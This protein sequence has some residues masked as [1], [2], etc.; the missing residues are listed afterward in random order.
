MSSGYNIDTATRYF[1]KINIGSK[2]IFL[3]EEGQENYTMN[4]DS[5]L[6]MEDLTIDDLAQEPKEM[7]P[8]QIKKMISY[9]NGKVNY[10]KKQ[11]NKLTKRRNRNKVAKKSRKKNRKK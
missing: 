2:Y 4:T 6:E 9:F 5:N 1:N 7:S 8:D 10:F 11:E 3:E